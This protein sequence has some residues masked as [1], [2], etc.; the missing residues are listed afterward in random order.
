M[1]SAKLAA[2]AWESILLMNIDG[3]LL[4]PYKKWVLLF[5]IA[6]RLRRVLPNHKRHPIEHLRSLQEAM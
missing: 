3:E 4:S 2:S 6:L 1:Q 5:G